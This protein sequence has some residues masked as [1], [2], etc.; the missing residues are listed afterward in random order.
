MKI[1]NRPEWNMQT[2]NMQILVFQEIICMCQSEFAKMSNLR[3]KKWRKQVSF[4][5]LIPVIWC[6][7]FHFQLRILTQNWWWAGVWKRCREPGLQIRGPGC[8]WS[9]W[10]LRQHIHYT[11]WTQRKHLMQPKQYYSPWTVH[12]GISGWNLADGAP[13]TCLMRRMTLFSSSGVVTGLSAS[14]R[15]CCLMCVMGRFLRLTVAV[16]NALDL[17]DCLW[18]SDSTSCTLF[19]SSST[20]KD[21]TERN[22]DYFHLYPVLCHFVLICCFILL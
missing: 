18:G 11:Q 4:C 12:K 21:S 14:S 7:G 2:W 9:V 15:C 13:A 16:R 8:V 10:I 6:P 5:H 1:E 3:E 22:R 19:N 20:H 17:G